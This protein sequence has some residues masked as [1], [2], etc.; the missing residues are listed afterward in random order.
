VQVN[1]DAS[2]D[3][4]FGDAANEPSLAI[5]AVDPNRIVVGWRQFDSVLSDYRQAG[6][7]RS[8]DGGNSWTAQKTLES[9]V[10]RSDPVLQADAD[11]N[12]YYFSLRPMPPGAPSHYRVSLFKSLD[13]GS[14]W[15]PSVD[16][17]GGDK[18]WFVIDRTEGA[19]RGNVYGAWNASSAVVQRTTSPAP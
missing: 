10:F 7:S 3:N 2:G 15:L 17:G 18:E 19:G 14:T 8:A 11:G 12:F 4:I 9:G 16:A 5:S 1:V 6:V 13:G